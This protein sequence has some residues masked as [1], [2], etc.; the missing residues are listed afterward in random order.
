MHRSAF[1]L[2]VLRLFFRRRRRGLDA[3]KEGDGFAEDVAVGQAAPDGIREAETRVL[4]GFVELPS[5]LVKNPMR[6]IR[7]HRRDQDGDDAEG[8]GERVNAASS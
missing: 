2:R 5:E 4:A 6:R 3:G 7:Q 1:C 8:F